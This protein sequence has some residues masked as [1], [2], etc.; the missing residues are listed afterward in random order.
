MG[1]RHSQS[2]SLSEGSQQ[3]YEGQ[4]QPSAAVQPLSHPS[5]S[6]KPEF[7]QP[8][9]GWIWPQPTVCQPLD[10]RSMKDILLPGKD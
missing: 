8:V 5:G 2:Y 1:N 9:M 3:L 7:H 4:A 6:G 10:W